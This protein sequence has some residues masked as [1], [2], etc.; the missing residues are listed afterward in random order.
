MK[1]VIILFE[2]VFNHF[3]SSV[4]AFEKILKIYGINDKSM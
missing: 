4:L 1:C 3:E 2:C